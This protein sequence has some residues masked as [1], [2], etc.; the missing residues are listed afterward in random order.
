MLQSNSEDIFICTE[1]IDKRALFWLFHKAHFFSYFFRLKKISL[2]QIAEKHLCREKRFNDW[3]F[4]FKLKYCW[5][6]SYH[7]F[8]QSQ[9]IG[10]WRTWR[11]R[12]NLNFVT[13]IDTVPH[14]EHERI[15]FILG[16]CVCEMSLP[17]ATWFL[18]VRIK[19][20]NI[21]INGEGHLELLWLLCLKSFHNKFKRN[22]WKSCSHDVID[23]AKEILRRYSAMSWSISMDS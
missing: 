12:K 16:V 2:Q 20:R 13:L 6:C 21:L 18:V 5:Q 8:F 22:F 4:I 11:L 7:C 10:E 15:R 3:G 9:H 19:H 23:I 17:T 1:Q 14:P